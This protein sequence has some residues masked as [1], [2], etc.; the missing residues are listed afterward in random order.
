MLAIA[1]SIRS[2]D[3][4]SSRHSLLPNRLSVRPTQDVLSVPF[5]SG[6]NRVDNEGDSNSPTYSHA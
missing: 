2:L 5:S 4:F 6:I 3:R 1:L